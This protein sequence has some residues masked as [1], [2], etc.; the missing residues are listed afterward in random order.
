MRSRRAVFLLG[1][2]LA[3]LVGAALRLGTYRQLQDGVR[4]R[5]VSS[6]DYYH[7]RRARFAVA[8]FPRTILFDPLMNFPRGA[9]A[10]WPPLFDLALAAPALLRHG[11]R[12]PAEAIERAAAWMPLVFAAGSI[13]L[14]ALLARRVYGGRAGLF[15]A[16][17]VAVAPA[18]ILW[19]QY[20]HVEQHC[21]E[22]FFGLAALTAY[23]ASRERPSEP[24][25]ARREA[26]AGIILALAV[27]AWQGAIFWGA[28]FALSLTIESLLARR[29]VFRAAI[30]TLLLPAALVAAATAAWT[31]GVEMPFTYVSFGY[32]QPMF[33]LAL[34]GGT[35]LLD[36]TIGLA[37]RSLPRRG[38]LLR[39][40]FV[41][42][43]LAVLLPFAGEILV[44][45]A[46]G[47]GYV[48]GRT[49]EVSGEAGYLSYP[50]AWLKGIFETRPLFADGVG[51]PLRQLSLAL[52]FVPV[53]IFA[54]ARRALARRRP[55]VH[56]AL[57]VW[58]V[59]TVFLAVSQRVNVYYAVPLCALAL[60][61]AGR[62]AAANIRRRTRPPARPSRPRITALAGIVLALPMIAG[63]REELASER[64]PGSD[65]FATLG[66][67]RRSLPHALDPYD[68]RLLRPPGPPELARAESVLAP[69][70]LGHLL[71]YEAELPVVAN[72]FGYGFLE[73]IRFFLAESEEEALAVAR[74]HRSRWILATDLVPRMNDYAG[75]L[76][77]A[78]PLAT[79][80]AGLTPTSAY[81][82]TMQSRL[83]DFDGKEVALPDGVVP[84]LASF[85]LAFTSRTGIQRGGRFVARWK[86]F[87][88][89]DA[90]GSG[91][92]R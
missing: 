8:H 72:N 67:M 65:L 69:W 40:A 43:V 45:F 86:V 34:A 63:I 50:S 30:L 17:F 26:F 90:P 74:R 20:G 78:P 35:A 76:G 28:I 87:E 71:L 9:V 25:N 91:P 6:D 84:A 57:V 75:Y 52:F 53:A 29:L 83:Y 37:R 15:A 32:F 79:S 33:L 64:V 11:S 16:L 23:L 47:V 10:I 3:I 62:L 82:R 68:A 19:S 81:F 31:R 77:K 4:T 39:A 89:L 61:E 54:W 70:S 48:A 46:G 56:V 24:G 44:S 85:R 88:I 55:G 22:S 36:M 41:T 1:I 80:V 92:A 18:H 13:A 38:L 12:A 58:A 66:W 27:L 42:A 59:V 21:A 7:L 49:W 51:P 60:V 2:A 5:A 14:A 73:S